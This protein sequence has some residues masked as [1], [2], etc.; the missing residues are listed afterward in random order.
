MAEDTVTAPEVVV[1]S[2]AG[3]EPE[4]TVVDGKT[5]GLDYPLRFPKSWSPSKIRAAV[6]K[7]YP[8]FKPGALRAAIP[9][10][11]LSADNLKRTAGLYA[12]D[13][14][15]AVS[16]VPVML[17]SALTG[18][19]DDIKRGFNWATGRP[20]ATDLPFGGQTTGQYAQRALSSLGLPEP[21][22]PTEHG[23]HSVFTGALGAATGAGAA[24]AIPGPVGSALSA[25]PLQQTIAGGAGAAAAEAAGQMTDHNRWAETG[26]GVVGGTLATLPR[27]V[28]NAGRAAPFVGQDLPPG[29]RGEDLIRQ[30]R[31]DMAEAGIDNP[32]AGLITEAPALRSAESLYSKIPGSS[33]VMYNAAVGYH[34]KMGAQAEALAD[35]LDKNHSPA[36]ASRIIEQV[37]HGDTEGFK[38]RFKLLQDKLYTP[39]KA[40]LGPDPSTPPTN[41]Q[42]FLRRSTA[43]YP[44]APFSSSGTV[45]SEIKGLHQDL[46]RDMELQRQ[47]AAPPGTPG[48]VGN[49]IINTTG[50][51]NDTS[52]FQRGQPPAAAPATATP[53]GPGVLPYDVLF[54][55]RQDIGERMRTP[56]MSGTR[57]TAQL[58]QAY[59]ALTKD[60]TL[61]YL[62]ADVDSGQ[63]RGP[64]AALI[65]Q[66]HR[67]GRPITDAQLE[68]ARADGGPAT[69][70]FERANKVTEV[71]HRRM[72]EVLN[73][74]RGPGAEIYDYAVNSK[75]MERSGNRIARIMHSFDPDFAK[76]NQPDLRD[77]IKAE[78]IANMGRAPAHLQS[79]AGDVWS[80]A[81]FLTNY[82]KMGSVAKDVMF[83]GMDGA[84]RDKL[85][86]LARVAQKLQEGAR[87]FANPSGT[88]PAAELTLTGRGLGGALMTGALGTAG[89]IMAGL[90]TRRMSSR[91]MFDPK[92]VEWLANAQSKPSAAIPAQ[93]EILAQSYAKDD[94]EKRNEIE[95]Y[96]SGVRANQHA[97]ESL[98][99]EVPPST[100]RQF[101]LKHAPS[102]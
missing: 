33:D 93:L 60:L 39:A 34:S 80:G 51:T 92:F 56:D 36:K 95:R 47:N 58:S 7:E 87:V 73:A 35:A 31:R 83:A 84:M 77:A 86:T 17:G 16:G 49:A 21:E 9:D 48:R 64:N 102:E 18:T 27:S 62:G 66:A 55:I 72:D 22:T 89:I 1:A 68:L 90:V 63:A 12:R 82:G 46:V 37:L 79:A 61:A 40:M 15:T 32:S 38:D 71:G 3:K 23:I 6:A 85:D 30:N 100:S 81:T 54:K 97:V 14:V 69:R 96:I 28:A 19:V 98:K 8:E 53:A 50:A 76:K 67:N 5:L 99:N 4:Y 25:A 94:P 101:L 29:M 75:E 88:T 13:A 44:E 20:M 2:N 91:M 42:D 11:F 45:N 74:A 57:N 59:K 78:F 65:V 43:I 26:A 52:R 24:R 10:E 41:Y 70:A